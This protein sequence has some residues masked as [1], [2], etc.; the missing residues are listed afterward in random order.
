[1]GMLEA[2]PQSATAPGALLLA[3]LSQGAGA[4]V[5]QRSVFGSLTKRC[6][7]LGHDHVSVNTHGEATAH[8]PRASNE[9]I[10]RVWRDELG[11]SAV[12]TESEEMGLP[13]L[14]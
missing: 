6:I 2:H 5:G 10:V 11:L 12:T 9:Q 7:L 13:G 8:V 3:V 14:L 4:C 1:V